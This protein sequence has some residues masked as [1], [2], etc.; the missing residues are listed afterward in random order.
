MLWCC[1]EF[2]ALHHRVVSGGSGS[3]KGEEPEQLSW[4]PCADASVSW[5]LPWS[6]LL[7]AE[8]AAWHDPQTVASWA[9][10][11]QPGAAATAGAGAATAAGAGAGARPAGSD[12]LL[13]HRR[14][15]GPEGR[16]VYTAH[17]W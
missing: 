16:V 1:A 17:C 8:V 12:T 14:S 13:L 3:G 15:R 7:T 9:V 6:E 2:A 10:A 11:A 4:V 5:H